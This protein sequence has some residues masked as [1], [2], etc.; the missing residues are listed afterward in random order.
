[1]ISNSSKYALKAILYLAVNT[2]EEE[3]LLAKNLSGLANVPKAYLSKLLQKLVRHNLISS[4]RGPHGGFYLTE[5]N[6]NVRLIEVINLI[7]GIDRLTSCMLSLNKCD[8]KY[9]CPLHESVGDMKTKF[10][11]NL[12]KT[13][14][15]DLV[16]DIKT[17]K[18]FL[19]L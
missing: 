6:R 16:E 11:E 10:I 13:S 12:E 19:P 7:D 5:E 9:P 8:E 4:V 3:K 1:M 15:Q 2:S 17:G 14:I 18:S